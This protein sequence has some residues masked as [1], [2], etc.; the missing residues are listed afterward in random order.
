MFDPGSPHGVED[1]AV[2]H[3]SEQ[4][5]RRGHVMRNGL[6]GVS[7]KSVRRPD[8]V[9]HAVVQPQ[10]FRGSFKLKP[11]VNP[12]LTEEHVHGVLLMHI[13]YMLVDVKQ[14][15]HSFTF[16]SSSQTFTSTRNT[17]ETFQL[18][19]EGAGR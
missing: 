18:A 17:G 15:T 1:G 13:H 16:Q 4:F 10:D 9:H 3:D 7:E 14:T 5:V 19:V 8:L 6:L 2:L 12:H 11:L